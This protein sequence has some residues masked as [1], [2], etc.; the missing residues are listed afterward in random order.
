V[1]A[2]N[3]VEGVEEELLLISVADLRMQDFGA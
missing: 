1:S 2:V 3:K